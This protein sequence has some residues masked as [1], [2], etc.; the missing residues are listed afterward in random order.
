MH[1]ALYLILVPTR[2]PSG[3][4]VLR[5]GTQF[6]WMLCIKGT[7]GTKRQGEYSKN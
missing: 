4:Q 6:R 7:K 3:G 1:R 2:L 5:V